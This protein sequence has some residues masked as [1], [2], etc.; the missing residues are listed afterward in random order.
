MSHG[1]SAAGHGPDPSERLARTRL[2]IL[3]ELQR[4]PQEGGAGW[5]ALREAGR[6]CWRAHPLRRAVGLAAP[7]LAYGSQRHPLALVG[8]AAAAGA[9]L[10]LARPWRWVSLPGLLVTALKS[11]PLASL[12]LRLLT[13]V[14]PRHAAPSSSRGARP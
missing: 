5:H 13:D 1:T 11:R 12:A 6:V 7:L 9:L 4:G 2:A 10:V 3:D 8:I 14:R